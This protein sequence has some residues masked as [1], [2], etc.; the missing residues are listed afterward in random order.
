MEEVDPLQTFLSIVL[1]DPFFS[2]QWTH[3]A[4]LEI[5]K[6]CLNLLMV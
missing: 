4:I 5:H 6:K 3:R 2:S 1:W